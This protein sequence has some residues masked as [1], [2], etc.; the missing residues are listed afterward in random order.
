VQDD[1]I[2]AVID[3][4]NA[5]YGDFLHDIACFSFWASWYRTM[6]G[7]DW[8]VEAKKHFETIGLEV[9]NIEERLLCYK[10]HIGLD[11]QAYNAFVGNWDHFAVNSQKTLE[12]AHS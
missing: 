9:P 12:L 6:D 5:L 8:E 4:G 10:I 1:R 11:A 7:I 2:S 3:W